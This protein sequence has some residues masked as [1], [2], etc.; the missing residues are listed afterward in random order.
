MEGGRENCFMV[1][2]A[3]GQA[4]ATLIVGS[5]T[6]CTQVG[7]SSTCMRVLKMY[8][9][10]S[11]N[12]FVADRAM[13]DHLCAVPHYSRATSTDGRYHLSRIYRSPRGGSRYGIS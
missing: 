11:K 12:D 5:F 1:S 2:C 8:I 7:G 10:T 13:Y 4:C 3:C 6:Q 9:L